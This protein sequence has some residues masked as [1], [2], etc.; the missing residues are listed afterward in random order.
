MLGVSSCSPPLVLQQ[1][2]FTSPSYVSAIFQGEKKKRLLLVLNRQ[3]F[4]LDWQKDE[5][6][7]AAYGSL[8]NLSPQSFQP[9]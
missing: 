5:N 8:S 7:T 9:E 4:Q 2:H 6:T 3:E 1:A